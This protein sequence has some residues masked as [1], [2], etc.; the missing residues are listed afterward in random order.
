MTLII[1]LFDFFIIQQ[2]LKR[3]IKQHDDEREYKL[4]DQIFYILWVIVTIGLGNMSYTYWLG[5]TSL[6]VSTIIRFQLYTLLIGI[7][8]A[9]LFVIIDYNLMLRQHLATA[10]KLNSKLGHETELAI[11]DLSGDIVVLTSDNDKEKV[12]LKVTN[13]FFIKS[14]GNYVEVY[15]RK[16]DTV[17]TILLRSTLTRVEEIV[18][19]FSHLFRCHRAYIVNSKKVRHVSGNSQGYRLQLVDTN[20]EIPVSRNYSKKLK[21]LVMCSK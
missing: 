4:R 6:A 3:L 20:H 14:E 8:P 19:D 21:E 1:T 11:G 15:V 5:Y 12:E 13:I 2:I 18:H 17:K 9:T 10:T 16:G 7:F